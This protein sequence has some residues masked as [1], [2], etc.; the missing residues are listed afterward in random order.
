MNKRFY[1]ELAIGLVG[2]AAVLYFG[3]AGFA[4]FALFAAYP[5]VAKKKAD[6]REY[7]LFYY[8]G[9]ITAIATFLLC[10]VIY[11][12]SDLVING[13]K[14]GDLW[15]YLVCFSFLAVHGVSGLVIFSRSQ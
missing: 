7:Q 12:G 3:V 1:F 8:T 11:L 13:N 4:V 5:W 14:I 6:E 9:N 2:I 15:L 10:V